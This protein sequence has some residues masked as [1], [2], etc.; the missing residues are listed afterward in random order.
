VSKVL[1]KAQL[2][3]ARIAAMEAAIDAADTQLTP[4]EA[5]ILPGGAPKA[6]AFHMARTVCRR[7]ERAVVALDHSA[8]VPAI[9]VRYVNRLSDLLFTLARL[10]NHQ[11][12]IRETTW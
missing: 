5:F 1:A 12:G 9:I 11:A 2:D 4:L 6:A 8:G 10:A 7:A 3:D